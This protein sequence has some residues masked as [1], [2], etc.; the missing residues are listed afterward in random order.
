M[1]NSVQSPQV[2]LIPLLRKQDYPKGLGD[3]DSVDKFFSIVNPFFQGIVNALD[4][5]LSIANLN[6]E[7]IAFSITTP[8]LTPPGAAGPIGSGGDWVSLALSQGWSS[9]IANSQ[10]FSSPRYRI[11]ADGQIQ[12]SGACEYQTAII[13]ATPTPMTA[14]GAL[15][16]T[17]YNEDMMG[18]IQVFNNAGN[19]ENGVALL[20]VDPNGQLTF[21]SKSTV[22]SSGTGT[23]NSIQFLSLANM[24]Y[25]PATP[26]PGVLA[27]WPINVRLQGNQVPVDIWITAIADTAAAANAGSASPPFAPGGLVWHP[28]NTTQQTG[29]NMVSID[30]IPNLR[31]GRTYNIRCWVQYASGVSPSAMAGGANTIG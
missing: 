30:N 10:G 31:L 4:G 13:N 1:A 18:W 3:E 15:P 28:I 2:P 23:A 27:C 19:G 14:L 24:F 25:T 17:G 7:I 12:F 5:S 22:A 8:S 29:V 6:G 11:N 9:S 21:R 16:V 20:R 26:V